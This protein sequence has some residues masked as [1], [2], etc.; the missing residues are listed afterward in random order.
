MDNKPQFK[1]SYAS[2]GRADEPKSAP[3][4]RTDEPPDGE[5]FSYDPTVPFPAALRHDPYAILY[6]KPGPGPKQETSQTKQEV[7]PTMN[8]YE[9]PHSKAPPSPKFGA[10][11]QPPSAAKQSLSKQS[12]LAVASPKPR[13]KSVGFEQSPVVRPLPPPPPTPSSPLTRVRSKSSDQSELPQPDVRKASPKRVSPQV[14]RMDE[15]RVHLDASPMAPPKGTYLSAGPKSSSL[16]IP[17]LPSQTVY[18]SPQVS[19]AHKPSLGCT[20]LARPDEGSAASS[21]ERKHSFVSKTSLLSLK[22]AFC[23]RLRT[24]SKCFVC[25]QCGMSVHNRCVSL[26]SSPCSSVMKSSDAPVVFV[27]ANQKFRGLRAV[28]LNTERI[29]CKGYLFKQSAHGDW[30][31]R[32]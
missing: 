18:S 28:N 19:R 2:V 31:T 6:D 15:Q 12:S 5:P 10:P 9:L 11:K 8:P 21:S 29:I 32:R 22:C 7:P 1:Y 17:S 27:S 13:P 23:N 30:N 25:S 24:T 16:A 4:G 20:L 14:Q 3:H 26:V